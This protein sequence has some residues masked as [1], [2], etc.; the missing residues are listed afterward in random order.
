MPCTSPRPMKMDSSA[1]IRARPRPIF[2]AVFHA[3]GG[4]TAH[5]TSPPTPLPS[6]RLR[7]AQS[8][9]SGQALRREGR[10][11]VPPSLAGRGS[12]GRWAIFR[13][14]AHV[15]RGATAGENGSPPRSKDTKSTRNGKA[16]CPSCLGTFVVRRRF[17]GQAIFRAV[18]HA[19]GG[20]TADETSP[21]TPLPSTRLRR[22]QS[23]RSGQAL[24][25]E[26]RHSVPPSLAGR[27]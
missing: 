7:R 5:E 18:F 4:A 3:A 11:S 20:A 9:R 24:R 22:A 10:H 1:F 13:A 14:V 25:R 23:S 19:A 8:S 12:G 16:L 2:R 26:G 15:G 21:P 6:T 27:G 17:S